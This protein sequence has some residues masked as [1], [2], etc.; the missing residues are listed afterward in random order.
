MRAASDPSESSDSADARASNAA[1]SVMKM[2][3]SPKT[4]TQYK[5]KMNTIEAYFK[6]KNFPYTFP[7]PVDKLIAFF[8][9]LKGAELAEGINQTKQ[10]NQ[11]LVIQQTQ[12]E[13]DEKSLHEMQEE[14][15]IE[16]VV[17]EESKQPINQAIDSQ[18]QSSRKRKRNNHA[19]ALA[20][21]RG[22]KSAL[23]W[24]YGE[25]GLLWDQALDAELE[26]VLKGWS[27]LVATLKQQ[28]KMDVVEGKLP[29]SVQGF[30]TL[31]ETLAKARVE[32]FQSKRQQRGRN[33]TVKQGNTF[34]RA[35]FGW[36]FIV[37]Q[38][39]LL[40]RSNSIATI[41]LEHVSWQ[42]DALVITIPKSKSDQSGA[43]SIPRHLYANTT[44]PCICPVL[45]FAVLVF[46][47]SYRLDP[48]SNK[49]FPLFDG[50]DNEGRFS[51]LLKLMI[52]KLNP[53]ELG[54][55]PEELG[56]HSIRKGAASHCTGMISGPSTVQVFLR[57][58]W[59]LGNVQD[60]YIFAEQG[61]DQLTGRVL[62]GLPFNDRNFAA[63]PPHFTKEGLTAIS[64]PRILPMYSHYPV[65]FQHALP[66]LLASIVHH[67]EWLQKSLDRNHPFFSSSLMSS[68]CIESLKPYVLT[69]I[70]RC[71]KT[72]MKATG[73]PPFLA[74]T[75]EFNELNTRTS[76]N[77]E[78]I[79]QKIESRFEAL[80]SVLTQ[81]LLQH[82]QINGAVPVTASELQQ[83]FMAWAEDLKASMTMSAAHSVQQAESA[84][85]VNSQPVFIEFR[86]LNGSM[87]CVPEDFTF[88]DV[89]V[90]D[91][92]ILWLFGHEQ[93]KIRPYRFIRK[94]DLQR[95]QVTSIGVGLQLR[96]LL[97][98]RS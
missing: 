14:E 50:T 93:K 62:S 21:V 15:A 19:L 6:A 76:V 18:S 32:D 79:E 29:L 27:R 53:S 92:W 97:Q 87:H 77:F 12:Q 33:V 22:Y 51:E 25:E 44:E 8:G 41:M 37:L 66:N 83:M 54:C 16:E 45:A 1:H 74:L 88:P 43:N 55:L 56:T 30:E 23:K 84:M 47:K 96:S 46:S 52:N 31:A 63:L 11:Q 81:T 78:R 20:T 10:I 4:M 86:W 67:Y 48:A 73:I 34:G 72:G 82:F 2:R 60:R 5:S 7:L 95:K 13:V 26:H 17:E 90:H 68:G 59:S 94:P 64:W 89:N 71:E 91:L 38:W 69:G 85:N 98:A 9:S 49:S 24:K 40:A 28:A 75:N 58:G 42:Q 36:A 70:N 65:A 39:N 3:I 80:P 35:L 61:G 57:A